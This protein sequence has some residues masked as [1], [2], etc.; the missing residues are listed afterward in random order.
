[1]QRHFFYWEFLESPLGWQ[2]RPLQP[3]GAHPLTE[4]LL[5][6]YLV[7]DATR[8]YAADSFEIKQATLQRRTHQT[9]G[10]RSLND[11]AMDTLLTLLVN[12]RDG[13]RVND[14]VDLAQP[15]S[16]PRYNVQGLLKDLGLPQE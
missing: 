3:D 9:S 4:L 13:A 7:V 2:D 16:L 5:A 10:G 8:P 1:V 15:T 11:D 14:G 12:A 6:D